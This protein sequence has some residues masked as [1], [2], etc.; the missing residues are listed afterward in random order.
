[1]TIAVEVL[2]SIDQLDATAYLTLRRSC[3]RSGQL[4]PGQ[5]QHPPGLSVVTS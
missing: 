5:P 2:T 3:A 4:L 1:M